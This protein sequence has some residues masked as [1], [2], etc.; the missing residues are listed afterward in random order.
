MLIPPSDAAFGACARQ[1]SLCAAVP[2]RNLCRCT[3]LLRPGPIRKPSWKPS[4]LSSTRLPWWPQDAARKPEDFT[5][6]AIAALAPLRARVERGRGPGD[7]PPALS[8]SFRGRGSTGWN[9]VDNARRSRT[10]GE[11]REDCRQDAQSARAGGRLG[12]WRGRAGGAPRA[13][14]RMTR[15]QQ[16]TPFAP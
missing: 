13:G 6:E 10:A 11:R 7:S 1:A 9:L 3:D 5:P 15:A 14:R 8:R 2:C 16:S 4:S 12:H